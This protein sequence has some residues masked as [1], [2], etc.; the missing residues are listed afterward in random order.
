[1]DA[2]DGGTSDD[3]IAFT[4]IS[5]KDSI[6]YYSNNWVWDTPTL[7]WKTVQQPVSNTAGIAVQID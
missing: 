7:S 6:M 1:M 2:H 5:S 3:T 4:V